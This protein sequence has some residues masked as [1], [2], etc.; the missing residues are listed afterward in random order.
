MGGNFGKI[1]WLNDDGSVLVD[2]FFVLQ[3]GVVVQVWLFGYCNVLGIVFDVCGKLWVYEM[4]LVGGDELN[5]IECGVNYGYLV[6]FNG[7]YYDG[8]EIF[9]YSIW[10]EFV[11]LK[12]IWMLVILLVGFIIYF[13]VLFLQWKGS[14]FIGGLLLILLVWVVFDGDNV[15]EVECFFMGECICE[16]E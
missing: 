2:N 10:F 9:D 4:G 15:C 3:G 5:L 1:V 8:C 13:G 12:V 7:N 11:V 16:V 6:V 14:G